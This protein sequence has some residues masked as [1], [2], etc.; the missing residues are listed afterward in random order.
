M[1]ES[2]RAEARGSLHKNRLCSSGCLC[3]ERVLFY[4]HGWIPLNQGSG[5]RRLQ[6]HREVRHRCV[7]TGASEE[8]EGRAGEL[9]A[10]SSQRAGTAQG[11]APSAASRGSAVCWTNIEDGTIDGGRSGGL[12]ECLASNGHGKSEKLWTV[13]QAVSEALPDGDKEK[14]LMQGCSTSGIR[15]KARR[16][17]RGRSRE[18]GVD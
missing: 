12:C 16:R 4:V 7:E 1:G 13:A 11:F 15:S 17:K 5:G 2:A 14:Q 10:P 9:R 3:G 8:G 18:L 6:A